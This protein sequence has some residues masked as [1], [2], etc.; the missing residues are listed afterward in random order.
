MLQTRSIPVYG[1][2]H[3]DDW[4]TFL[5]KASKGSIKAPDTLTYANMAYMVAFTNEPD[6][7]D[8]VD[9]DDYNELVHE[10]FPQACPVDSIQAFHDLACRCGWIA[11]PFRVSLTPRNSPD[12]Y[13]A[14]WGRLPVDETALMNDSMLHCLDCWSAAHFIECVD[15]YGAEYDSRM[16]TSGM[17]YLAVTWPSK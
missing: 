2:D 17:L 15:H 16:V 1:D 8:T 3:A 6:A 4:Q 12:K 7:P 5:Y 11:N 14:I 13:V 10:R 9:L